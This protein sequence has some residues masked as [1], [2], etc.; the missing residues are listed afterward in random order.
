MILLRTLSYFFLAIM[1]CSCVT[2]QQ[3]VFTGI[4]GFKVG[5]VSTEGIE[6]DV[7]L[8]IQNPNRF[9]FTVYRSAF[10]VT[11]TGIH[12]GAAE[13]SKKVKIKAGE[14][15][16]YAF[17]LKS[18]CKDIDLAQVLRLLN[19]ATRR[20]VMEIK[21]TLKVGRFYLKKSFPVAVNERLG[22]D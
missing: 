22:F 11:F 4:K 19:S 15:G 3:P 5:K 6:G 1:A 18:D 8:G 14:E 17:H 7:M 20:D 21:G 13:L 12:L 9:A 10:E 16:T 2:L